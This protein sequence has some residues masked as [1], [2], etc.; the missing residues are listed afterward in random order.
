MY[1]RLEQKRLFAIKLIIS[2]RYSINEIAER[3][4]VSRMTLWKWRQQPSFKKKLEIDSTDKK[5]IKA[6]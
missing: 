4:N 6:I 5:T 1:K 2:K 3:C